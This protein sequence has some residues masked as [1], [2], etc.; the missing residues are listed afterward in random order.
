ML[1][2][3]HWHM[4]LLAVNL[5]MYKSLIFAS[6]AACSSWPSPHDHSHSCLSVGIPEHRAKQTKSAPPCPVLAGCLEQQLLLQN[7]LPVS[8]SMAPVL[9]QS[10]TPCYQNVISCYQQSACSDTIE[11]PL[12]ACSSIHGTCQSAVS[13]CEYWDQALMEMLR[14]FV[15]MGRMA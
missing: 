2:H 4:D 8:G 6:L 5:N 10:R 12:C 14:A 13:M 1:C 11:V 9:K 15:W 7:Q 3:A